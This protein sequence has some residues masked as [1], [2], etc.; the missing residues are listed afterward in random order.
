[1]HSAPRS[2]GASALPTRTTRAGAALVLLIAF[3]VV[4]GL[5]VLDAGRVIGELG[6]QRERALASRSDDTAGLTGE[7]AD[8]FRQFR[9]HLRKGER[10]ALVFAPDI[11]RDQEGFYRLVALSYLYPAIAVDDPGRADAVMVFGEQSPGIRADFEQIGAAAGV[12][13]GRRRP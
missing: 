1:M 11:G 8:A 12:W 2:P 3:A 7:A 4:V 9:A 10:F 6:D 13:L 5:G